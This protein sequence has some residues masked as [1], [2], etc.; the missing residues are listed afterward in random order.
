MAEEFISE[1]EKQLLYLVTF[2]VIMFVSL[3]KRPQRNPIS[4]TSK[5]GPRTERVEYILMAVDP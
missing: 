3:S 5:D 1:K 2:F 4:E